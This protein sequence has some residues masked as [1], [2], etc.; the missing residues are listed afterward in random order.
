MNY[1]ALHPKNDREEA[2]T[3]EPLQIKYIDGIEAAFTALRG[4]SDKLQRLL[5]DIFQ[6]PWG[7]HGE[8]KPEVLKRKYKDHTGEFHKG[9]MS[10]RLDDKNRLIYKVL[11]PRQILL[12]AFVGHYKRK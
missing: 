1:M 4:T 2:K 7:T 9:C 5:E 11:G 3:L 6:K 8:G 10:R 12:I